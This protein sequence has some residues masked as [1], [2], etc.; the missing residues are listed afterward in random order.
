[1]SPS[2][3]CVTLMERVVN[4]CNTVACQIMVDNEDALDGAAD[5][6]WEVF[7][8]LQDEKPGGRV[9]ARITR[10]ETNSHWDWLAIRWDLPTHLILQLEKSRVHLGLPRKRP[11]L[12]ID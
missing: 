8:E 3:D 1:M 7:A 11:E 10:G 6:L 2:L 12:D 4:A 5:L 9:L